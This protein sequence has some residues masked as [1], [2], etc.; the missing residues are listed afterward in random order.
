MKALKWL[1]YVVGGLIVIILDHGSLDSDPNRLSIDIERRAP[2]DQR[3]K[4]SGVPRR[5]LGGKVRLQR[6]DVRAANLFE[7]YKRKGRNRR[8]VHRSGLDPRIAIRS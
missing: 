3:R 5:Q 6:C 8:R 1:G 4:M 2:G 7:S